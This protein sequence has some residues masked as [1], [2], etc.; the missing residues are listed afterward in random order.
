M[1]HL[2][3][4][5]LSNLMLPLSKVKNL[6]LST[7]KVII[8]RPQRQSLNTPRTPLN[9]HKNLALSTPIMILHG[10]EKLYLSIIKVTLSN[11]KFILTCSV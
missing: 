5:P 4:Q 10:L 6:G 8:D 9:K 2:I 7:P 11:L 1:D 3:A